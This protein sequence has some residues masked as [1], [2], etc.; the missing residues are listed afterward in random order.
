V[1]GWTCLGSAEQM[2]RA[3]GVNTNRMKIVGLG[4]ANGLTALSGFLIVQYQGFA[5]I[6]MGMGIMI[7]GLGSVIIGEA[8]AQLLKI[9]AIAFQLG[10]VLLGA[11]VFRELLAVALSTGLPHEMLHLATSV[12]VLLVV[13]FGKRK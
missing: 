1:L 4:I 2:I 11:I 10:M 12:M 7:V 13:V 5:D 3:N 8:L 6:N 9:R